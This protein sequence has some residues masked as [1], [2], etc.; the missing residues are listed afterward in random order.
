MNIV[1]FPDKPNALQEIIEGMRHIA[2]A[3]KAYYDSLIQ[4]GFT[5]QEALQLVGQFNW[6][7]A[8]K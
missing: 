7:S 4:Q 5:K 3:N 8:A 6:M 2:I 1:N